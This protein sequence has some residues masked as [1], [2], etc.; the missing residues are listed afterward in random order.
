MLMITIHVNEQNTIKYYKCSLSKFIF[1]FVLL[2]FS[3]IIVLLLELPHTI[4]HVINNIQFI[5]ILRNFK[6]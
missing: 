6:H 3:I 1:I 2:A 5:I 4:Y